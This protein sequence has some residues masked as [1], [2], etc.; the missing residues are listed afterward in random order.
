MKLQLLDFQQTAA[1]A[2]SKAIRKSQSDHALDPD[3]YG[4]VVLSAATGAGKTVIA[5]A[6]IEQ[7]LFGGDMTEPVKDTTVLWVTNDPSL[8]QQT[9]RKMQ[10]ASDK[11]ND[12]RL[13]GQGATFDQDTFDP[14][15]IYFINTQAVSSSARLARKSDTQKYTIW[16]TIENSVTKYGEKFLVFVDE[17]HHGV[18]ET[19]SGGQTIVNR[20]LAGARPVPVFVGIS[21]T[22]QKLNTALETQLQHSKRVPR[23]VDVPIADVRES[24]LV[25]DRVLLGAAAEEGG[26]I[27]DTT[28][29]RLGVQKTL[30]VEAKWKAYAE[31]QKEPRVIPALVVQVPNTPSNDE[32]NKVIDAIIQEWPGLTSTN[33]VHT[34]SEHTS[35]DLGGSRAIRYMPPQDIQ[36][37]THVRVVLAKNAVTTGWDCPR[38]EVLVS[39]RAS[40]DF[41]PIA[42]LIGRIVRQPLARRIG[43]DETLNKV[44]AY[45]PRFNQKTVMSVVAQFADGESAAAAEAVRITLDYT[46]PPSMKPAIEVLASL[47]TYVVPSQANAPETRRLHTLAVL[48]A[49]HAIKPDAIEEAREYLNRTLDQEA[50]K[51]G[52]SLEER[53]T[54]VASA[55]IFELQVSIDGLILDGERTVVGTRLDAK[56]VNDVF[57]RASRAMKDG[58]A[59]DYWAYLVDKDAEEDPIEAKITTAALGLDDFIVDN[60]HAAAASLTRD[61]IKKFGKQIADL[62]EAQRVGYSRLQAQ[63]REPQQRLGITVYGTIEDSVSI[64]TAEDISDDQLRAQIKHDSVNRWAMHLYQD[65]DDALYYKKPSDMD[66]LERKVLAKE[67]AGKGLVAWYRNPPGGDRAL[68]IPYKVSGTGRWARLYPDFIFFH[69]VGDQVMASIVDPHGLNLADWPDKLRGAVEYASSHAPE[70]RS[71]YPLTVVDGHAMV[72]ALHDEGTRNK[73]RAA[74]DGGDAVDAIFRDYGLMY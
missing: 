47:P 27:A 10:E 64:A 52:G 25:K 70:F 18:T 36:D 12:I 30:E 69:S 35:I 13:I 71:I 40:S 55:S 14:G 56:N 68:C 4:A 53:R 22:A 43:S 58:T 45:L 24:G 20:I 8:N 9:A 23:H 7:F 66:G 73:V 72:L 15:V 19:G 46:S 42:Q 16:D 1:A 31:D 67:L 38:A 34:F 39:L 62:P 37:A 6:V 60:L 50:L 17:A 33:I 59:E 29:V 26:V 44:F 21:A 28:F 65:P 48:L 54:A 32:L 61:W 49:N 74:L 41:T 57:G 51:L 63:S 3:E 5:T 2:L 11:I